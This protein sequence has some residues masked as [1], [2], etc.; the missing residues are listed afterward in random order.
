ME[1]Q[2][3]FGTSEEY[4]TWKLLNGKISPKMLNSITSKIRKGGQVHPAILI[5]LV[6]ALK[7]TTEVTATE[8][9]I[10]SEKARPQDIS[11]I[12]RI[13]DI[14]IEMDEMSAAQSIITTSESRDSFYRL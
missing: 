3:V 6:N 1:S 13:A 4:H 12:M 10:L 2:P 9:T 5:S 8:L 7:E 14:L 11:P